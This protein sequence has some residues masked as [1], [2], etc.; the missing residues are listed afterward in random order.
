MRCGRV[1]GRIVVWRS[2]GVIFD[3]RWDNCGYPSVLLVWTW[4]TERIWQCNEFNEVEREAQWEFCWS[5]LDSRCHCSPTVQKASL[6]DGTGCRAACYHQ[7]PG[8]RWSEW[9]RKQRKGEWRFLSDDD[10]AMTHKVHTLQQGK[11]TVHEKVPNFKR[12][13][14]YQLYDTR[15]LYK[16]R[17]R[18]GIML[19]VCR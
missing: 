7:V 9:P 8:E 16:M 14:F 13:F 10:G 11:I 4:Q 5:R 1:C 17:R 15:I 2:D 6:R 12:G 18:N 3:C 19:W